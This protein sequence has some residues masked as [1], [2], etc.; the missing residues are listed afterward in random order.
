M[1]KKIRTKEKKHEI[2]HVY[3]QGRFYYKKKTSVGHLNVPDNVP[4]TLDRVLNPY[5]KSLMERHLFQ[6]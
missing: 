2:I 6:F 4:W 3:L 5:N 1:K